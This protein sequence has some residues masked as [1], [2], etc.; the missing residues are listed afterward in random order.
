MPLVFCANAVTAVFS[1]FVVE[2]WHRRKQRKIGNSVGLGTFRSWGKEK[3]INRVLDI[4]LQKCRNV[5]L[6]KGVLES[7]EEPLAKKAKTAHS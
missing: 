5:S 2:S 6:S 4:Y 1:S 7:I 3:V